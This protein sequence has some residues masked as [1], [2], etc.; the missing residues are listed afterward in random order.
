MRLEKNKE[1]ELLA[2]EHYTRAG[3]FFAGHN[4]NE[5]TKEL[6]KASSLTKDKN[7]KK[8]ITAF[9]KE[10]KETEKVTKQRDKLARLDENK[11]KKEEEKKRNAAIRQQKEKAKR[12][13][14]EREKELAKKYRK[15]VR[16]Y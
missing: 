15:A 10:V 13:A 12:L 6:K 11:R 14:R 16:P 8:E 1:N 9:S 2:K 3:Q 7:L 5:A 4:F